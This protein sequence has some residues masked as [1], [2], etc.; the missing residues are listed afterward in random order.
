[1]LLSPKIVK[2]VTMTIRF[3]LIFLLFFIVKLSVAQ[4]PIICKTS[5][6]PNNAS[7]CRQEL[8]DPVCGCDTVTYRSPC[9]ATQINHVQFYTDGVCFMQPFA[10]DVYPIPCTQANPLKIAVESRQN[11]PESFTINI[12]NSYG[13][14]QL[15]RIVGK[16]ARFDWLVP[17][18]NFNPGVYIILVYNLNTGFVIKEKF[19]VGSN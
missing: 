9:D 18:F 1:M 2:F 4:I 8:Y 14:L 19:L 16:T 17:T 12:Y 13:V 15:Q 11:Q 10:L 3:S 6:I 5:T 7:N